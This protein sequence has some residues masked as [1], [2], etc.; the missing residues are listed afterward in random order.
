VDSVQETVPRLDD[1]NPM[2][3]G[4]GNSGWTARA[5]SIDP[6]NPDQTFRPL[7]RILSVNS[8]KVEKAIYPSSRWR[9]DFDQAVVYVPEYSF[10]APDGVTIIPETYDLGRSAALSDAI[11]GQ[12]LYV[13]KEINKTT[14]KLDVSDDGKVSNLQVIAPRGEYSTA[15]GPGGNLYIAD[16]Q[17]F[18]YNNNYKESR[19]IDLEERPISMAFGGK[20]GNT[21]FVTTHSSLFAIQVE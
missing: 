18:V 12:P 5:Y 6:D 8:G 4:W 20:D 1:D 21:L 19:R 11:P 14:V 10:V 3:S 16:G 13:S 2:Y 9:S 15:I 7:K 17:I